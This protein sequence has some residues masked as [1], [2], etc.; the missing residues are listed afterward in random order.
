DVDLIRREVDIID[1]QVIVSCGN[2]RDVARLFDL[3][4]VMKDD[5]LNYSRGKVNEK[6]KLFFYPRHPSHGASSAKTYAQLKA[7]WQVAHA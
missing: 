1:P 4:D 2:R 3:D 5:S 6:E 7:S